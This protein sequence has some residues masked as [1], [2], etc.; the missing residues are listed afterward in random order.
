MEFSHK[1]IMADECMNLLSIKSDGIYI[2]GTVGGAGHAT[3]ILSRL[4][5]GGRLIA[6]DRDSEAIAV[7]KERLA[8]VE[9]KAGFT[10]VKERYSNAA[11]VLRQ[12]GLGKVNGILLDIG[13]SSYQLDNAERGFGYMSDSK[14][15][16]RMGT[17]E[18][19]RSAY[20]IVN[21]A[22]VQELERI[23]RDYGEERWWK[24][25][26]QFIVKEREKAKI[27]TTGELVGII[28]AAIPSK[29]RKEKQHPAK[30]TFQALRIAVNR[31]LDELELLLDDLNE[32]LLPGGRAV[33][34]TFH[35]LEDRIVKTKFKEFHQP[36]TCPPG[37][38]ECVCGKKPTGRIITSKPVV[39][40][41][42]EMKSNPRARSAKLRVLEW[43]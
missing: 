6:I 39:P 19:I 13:V 32:I 8:K 24:R 3:H 20:D 25:I 17:D 27:E 16:M 23:I 26:A 31:E 5:E 38:P 7:A 22:D 34:I 43:I 11:Q 29:A 12:L 41:E 4:G 33:I 28:T 10:V 14:L 35:S 21:E 42:D 37:F 36:C 2:D 30:R 15:D 9:T 40:S 18:S 1:P